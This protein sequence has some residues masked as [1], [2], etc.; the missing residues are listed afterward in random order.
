MNIAIGNL[1]IRN[2][3]SEDFNNLY[4]LLSDEKVMRYLEPV[5]S[6]E[7]TAE[8]LKTAGLTENPLIYSVCRNSNFIGYVIYHKYDLKSYEIGWV[9]APDVWGTGIADSLTK[10]LIEYSKGKMDYLVIECLSEQIASKRIALKNGFRYFRK[11][12]N[13]EVYRLNLKCGS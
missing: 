3:I 13:L 2:F 8:F 6:K 12:D 4:K 5:F 7:K 9:L 1:I 11:I 10:M